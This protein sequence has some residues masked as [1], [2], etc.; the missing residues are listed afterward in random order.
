MTIQNFFLLITSQHDVLEK[1]FFENEK[2]QSEIFHWGPPRQSRQGKKQ[3]PLEKSLRLHTR[4][5][6]A[7]AAEGV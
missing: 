4:G 2:N 3:V 6:P 7:A 5:G 1:K